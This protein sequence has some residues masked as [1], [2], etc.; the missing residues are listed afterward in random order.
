MR[1]FAS[2]L[3]VD[4]RY[5]QRVRFFENKFA[6]MLNSIEPAPD[7]ISNGSSF[8]CSGS[9]FFADLVISEGP[10]AEELRPLS[11]TGE[12]AAPL[13]I[14]FELPGTTKEAGPPL[15]DINVPEDTPV[16][17]YTSDCSSH[18]VSEWSDS[19]EKK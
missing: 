6:L 19:S 7:T 15:T 13:T 12:N 18:E 10:S 1:C 5:A 4:H 9:R 2:T 16:V 3:D 11:Q 8:E 14:S 17:D